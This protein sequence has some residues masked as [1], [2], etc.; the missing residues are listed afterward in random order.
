[1]RKPG[2]MIVG[3][4][5]GCLGVD[6]QTVVTSQGGTNAP[7]LKIAVTPPQAV[8][9]AP[10]ATNKL[11]TVGGRTITLPAVSIKPPSVTVIPPTAVPVT[12]NAPAVA[13]TAKT[14][15]PPVV[16]PASKAAA[17]AETQAEEAGAGGGLFSRWFKKR[18]E[19]KEPEPLVLSAPK[20]RIS[21]YRAGQDLRYLDQWQRRINKFAE[22]A[23]GIRVYHIAKANAWLDFSRTEYALNPRSPMIEG[24]LSQATNLV[25]RLEGG[26][27]VEW[28][29]P[30]IVDAP[31]SC[32][33][34]WEKIEQLKKNQ[35][36]GKGLA[37]VAW[38]EI[39]LVKAAHITRKR[40]WLTAVDEYAKAERWLAVAWKKIA[41][42]PMQ[43]ATPG[44]IPLDA[45]GGHAAEFPA[46]K[47]EQAEALGMLEAALV[48]AHAAG[49]SVE[50]HGLA[51][52]A[53]W[54]RFAREASARRMSASVVRAL[55][56]ECRLSLARLG[57]G[58]DG[59]SWEWRE[60]GRSTPASDELRE[61]LEA[62][63]SRDQTGALG[64]LLAE[65]EVELARG[66][67]QTKRY[68]R[69]SGRRYLAKGRELA[70][71]AESALAAPLGIDE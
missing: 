4:I 69:G 16:A 54:L 51:R 62:L 45:W 44:P 34:M 55:G 32:P 70:A 15:A 61:R 17:K 57:A 65:A 37:E 21:D 60:I 39:Q 56:E 35:N 36:F 14:N 10:A 9:S 48:R 31:R 52:A 13:A 30:Q 68:G 46:R 47:R 18:K 64:R 40:G 23:S 19:V 53:Y 25:L 38:I 24:A 20:E 3:M 43:M 26:K 5:V 58:S 29:T 33:V 42:E 8:S 12:V 1:M 28:S 71:L 7:T 59:H 22:A 2:S 67:L 11:V 49:W 50:S 41:G 27:K 63:R 6:A 66:E